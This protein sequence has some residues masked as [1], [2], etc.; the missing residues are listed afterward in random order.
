[1]WRAALV[2]AG[3][4]AASTADAD[5]VARAPVVKSAHLTLP[6]FGHTIVN[7]GSSHAGMGIDAAVLIDR[8]W[9]VSAGAMAGGSG[10]EWLLSTLVRVGVTPSVIDVADVEGGWTLELGPWLGWRYDYRRDHDDGFEPSESLHSLAEGAHVDLT[11]WYP[12]KVGLSLTFDASLVL[13]LTRSESA[14]WSYRRRDAE[15]FRHAYDLRG[16]VGV[17]F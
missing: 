7:D 5:P 8:R 14:T 17:A 15:D 13:P 1:M 2:F 3:M 16:A 9:H 6:F 12:G 4:L 10:R 11:R